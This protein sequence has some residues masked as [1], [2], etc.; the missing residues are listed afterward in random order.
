MEEI[1]GVAVH[2]LSHIGNRDILIG[3][4]AVIFT[5]IISMVKVT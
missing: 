5:S 2:E 3:T 1:R 4:V